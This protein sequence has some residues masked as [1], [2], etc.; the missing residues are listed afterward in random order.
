MRLA[1]MCTAL[2]LLAGTLGA[3]ASSFAQAAN[4]GVIDPRTF[5]QTGYRIDRDSFWNYFS[6]RGGV[7]IFG[8]PVSRDFQFE[9][10]AAQFFQR[11]VMQ[12]CAGNGVGTMNLLDDGLLPYTRINGST[13]PAGDPNLTAWTPR[14]GEPFYA[15]DILAFVRAYAPDTF[16]GQPVNF[17]STFFNTIGTEV[18][19]TDEPNIL[20]LLALEIWGAPTSKPAYDPSNSNFIYQ[21][22]QRGI[23]HYDKGCGC[24]QGLLLADYLKALPSVNASATTRLL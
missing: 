12:Q 15:A 11:I 7:T 4:Q 10:C 20:G 18:G 22:F 14:V 17:Q 21:R 8:Y 5:V 6:N 24:T 2:L 1:A 3:P 19:G 16:D 9:G 23:M 13:F